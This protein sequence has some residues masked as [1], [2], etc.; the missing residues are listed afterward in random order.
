MDLKL[1]Q[2]GHDSGRAHI[3]YWSCGRKGGRPVVLV[4]G[5]S[6]NGLCWLPVARE[7]NDAY[8]IIMPDMVGHG[9][10]S[11]ASEV[12]DID[13][14]TDIVSLIESLGLEKPVVVGHSMGA[15]VSVQA[16]ARCPRL[17]AALVLEDPPWLSP[18]SPPIEDEG[19]TP[20]VA[21]AKTLHLRSLEELLA[22]Y[23]RDHPSWPDEL[24]AAMC[25]AKKQLDPGII[26]ELGRAFKSGVLSWPSILE[27][28]SIPLLVITADPS[29]G[30]IVGPE[31]VELIR[32]IKPDIEL[33]KVENVGHL[34]RFAAHTTFMRILRSF[35]EKTEH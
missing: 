33:A 8:C 16:V 29:L 23:R 32:S 15:M 20:I 7:L 22:E 34:I 35:L 13:M 31:A 27:S 11:R 24:V 28:I 9:L 4:H 12:K 18:S 5:F 30:A 14:A 26:D 2:G 3:N 19:E 1:E 25:E 17:A 21:W 10:S 6:D